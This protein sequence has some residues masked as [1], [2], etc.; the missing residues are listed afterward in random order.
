MACLVDSGDRCDTVRNHSF[1]FE[2]PCFYRVV[3]QH[4][5]YSG[6]MQLTAIRLVRY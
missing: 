3:E 5:S 4:A 6:C 1:R 2:K